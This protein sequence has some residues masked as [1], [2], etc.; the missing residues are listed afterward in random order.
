M[1]S[2]KSCS[3]DSQVLGISI[4]IR[5]YGILQHNLKMLRKTKDLYFELITKILVIL[6]RYSFTT[7]SNK[8]LP[9]RTT[10]YVYD[11]KIDNYTG[12]QFFTDPQKLNWIPISLKLRSGS[13]HA[14]NEC[15]RTAFPLTLAWAWTP[16]K[17]QP[18]KPKGICRKESWLALCL[19]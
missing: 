18:I 2:F 16:W 14:N 11:V 9:Q 15:T 1:N 4:Q 6:K 19:T 7:A 17:G 13:Y 12:P 8:M 3:K 5:K 10:F